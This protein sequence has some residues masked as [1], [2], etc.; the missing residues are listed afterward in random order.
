MVRN[1]RLRILL[2]QYSV[3]VV[4]FIFAKLVDEREAK[5]KVGRSNIRGQD[6]RVRRSVLVPPS[7]EG[8][9]EKDNNP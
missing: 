3:Q 8:L 1:R 2:I 4:V 5:T 9:R 7:F 6:F